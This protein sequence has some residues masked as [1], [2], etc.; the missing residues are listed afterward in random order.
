MKEYEIKWTDLVGYT[1]TIEADS[2]EEALAAFKDGDYDEA[3]P[4]GYVELKD[5]S[6]E[7]EEAWKT[8]EV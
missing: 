2:K 3:E 8:L 1:T 4:C 7:V 5:G 6:V